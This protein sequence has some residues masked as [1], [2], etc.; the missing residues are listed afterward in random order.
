MPTETAANRSVIGCSLRSPAASMRVKAS[1][2]ATNPPQIEAVRVPPSAWSTSQSTVTWRSATALR[3]TTA[4]SD[5]P[6]RRW[7]S[8]PRPELRR[9]MRSGLDPGSIE[10]SAVT[11]PRSEPRSQRGTSSSIEAVQSTRVRPNDTRH[12]PWAISVKSRSKASGRN[13]SFRRPSG[14]TG[15]PSERRSALEVDDVLGVGRRLVEVGGP[16]A[17]GKVLPSG[18][19]DDEHDHRL[20]VGVEALGDPEGSG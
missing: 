20:L 13:S 18:I 17:S 9:R 12:E 2:R 14:L 6:M 7:I 1:W 8:W 16:G 10:Y 3:S 19:T 15:P 4:R 5:R 11:Q